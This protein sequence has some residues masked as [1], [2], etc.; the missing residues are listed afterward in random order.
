[1]R[2][3]S[4]TEVFNDVRFKFQHKRQIFRFD[5]QINNNRL[6]RVVSNHKSSHSA[7]WL[8]YKKNKEEQSRKY[9]LKK[10]SKKERNCIK[11]N[12]KN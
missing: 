6:K 5:K 12:K 10:E 3:L 2:H 8:I 11:S 4:R 1:M 9:C 7:N